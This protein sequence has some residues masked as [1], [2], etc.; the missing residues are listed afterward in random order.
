MSTEC[1]S[2]TI[3]ILRDSRHRG[4]AFT[5]A[6][7][8]RALSGL[9]VVVH[10]L[11]PRAVVFSTPVDAHVPEAPPRARDN[12]AFVVV[13]VVVVN[14]V[15]V[16]VVVVVLPPSLLLPP[17]AP[18]AG[19]QAAAVVVRVPIP[20]VAVA[21]ICSKTVAREPAPRAP[22]SGRIPGRTRHT[23]C[24]GTRGTRTGLPRFVIDTAMDYSL[25]TLCP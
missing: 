18:D 20:V 5:A 23:N 13:D 21:L 7:P 24:G 10:L 22:R 8:G 25:P 17:P 11:R 4:V 2:V 1:V 12:D 19:V 3:D 9:S 6:G 15:V 16:D 14:V